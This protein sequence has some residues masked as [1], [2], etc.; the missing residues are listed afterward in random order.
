MKNLEKKAELAANI[1]IIA[2]AFVLLVVLANKFW[3][4]S[5]TLPVREIPIGEKILIDDINWTENKQTLLLVLQENCHFCTESMPFY[6][7]LTEKAQANTKTKLIALFPDSVEKSRNYLKS[8]NIEIASVRQFNFTKIGVGG[9]PTLI[10]VD[11]QG[12]VADSWVGKLPPEVEE[13]VLQKIFCN[14]GA[15]CS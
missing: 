11:E 14:D 10:L 8:Q 4:S 1:A 5:E 9:T 3:G 12:K 13:K 7:K 6:K 15:N 2:T